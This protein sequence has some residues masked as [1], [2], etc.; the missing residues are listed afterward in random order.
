MQPTQKVEVG[1]VWKATSSGHDYKIVRIRNDGGTQLATLRGRIG[2]L[3][4]TADF[5]R[6]RFTLV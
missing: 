3:E 1:S 6:S 5:V 4:V 2:E